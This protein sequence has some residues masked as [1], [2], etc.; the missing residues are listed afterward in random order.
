MDYLQRQQLV[1]FLL[2]CT[3]EV[4]TGVPA[5]RNVM[6]EMKETKMKRGKAL[7]IVL[8]TSVNATLYE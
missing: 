8:N 2:D 7:L 4:K 6:L 5:R 1:V 3:T